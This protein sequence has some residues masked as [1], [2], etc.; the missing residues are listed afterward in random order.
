MAAIVVD[1]GSFS[2]PCPG[3]I[4][5]EILCWVKNLLCSYSV[6]NV[7]K[8]LVAFCKAEVLQKTEEEVRAFLEGMEDA[9]ALPVLKGHP[10]EQWILWTLSRWLKGW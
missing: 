9:G 3:V 1:A 8:F 10:P 7:A 4:L 5:S 2:S 6:D